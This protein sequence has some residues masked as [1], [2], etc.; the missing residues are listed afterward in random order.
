M[1][2]LQKVDQELSLENQTITEQ[3]EPTISKEFKK[4]IFKKLKGGFF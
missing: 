2:R 3:L 1:E 4:D